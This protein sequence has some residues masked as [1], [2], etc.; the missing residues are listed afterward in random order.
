MY[1]AVVE[2]GGGGGGGEEERKCGAKVIGLKMRISIPKMNAVIMLEH[3]S[4]HPIN[5]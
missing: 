1:K 2:G 4:N 5:V 3:C